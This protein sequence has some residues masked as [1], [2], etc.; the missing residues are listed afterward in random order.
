MTTTLDVITNP[1]SGDAEPDLEILRAVFGDHG[2]QWE[3]RKTEEAGDA[4]RF[5][6][7]AAD[8]GA[9]IVVAYGGDGTVGEVAGGLLGSD[10]ALAIFPGGTANVIALDL[11]IPDDIGQAAH[12]ACGRKSITDRMDVGVIDREDADDLH[13]LWRLGIGF[14]AA[15]ISDADRGKKDRLG[16]AAYVWAGLR[17]LGKSDVAAYRFVIDGNEI[18]TRGVS[19]AVANSGTLGIPGLRWGSQISIRDGY[20]DVVVVEEFNLQALDAILGQAFDGQFETADE[21]DRAMRDYTSQ[22]E[23]MLHHWQG[24]EIEIHADPLQSVQYDGEVLDGVTQ[25]VRCRVLPQQLKVIVPVD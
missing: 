7:Q 14:E 15:L 24:R 16:F 25:P 19:F 1:A 3:L 23:G 22:I 12:L 8:A 9:E 17:N 10:T 18:E 2:V 20:L 6:R 5:A 4:R 21:H 13:F 11:G